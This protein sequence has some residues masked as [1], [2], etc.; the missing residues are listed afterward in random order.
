M[1]SNY[2]TRSSEE[3][4]AEQ[5]S[6]P[7]SVKPTPIYK[8]ISGGMATL[9]RPDTEQRLRS[10]TTNNTRTCVYIGGAGNGGVVSSAATLDRRQPQRMS[11]LNMRRA[12]ADAELPAVTPS[13]QTTR[14]CIS[15]VSSV[16]DSGGGRTTATS[17]RISSSG[18]IT[19]SGSNNTLTDIQGYHEHDLHDG[20]S[21][22]YSSVSATTSAHSAHNITT[23]SNAKLLPAPEDESNQQVRQLAG[24]KGLVWGFTRFSKINNCSWGFYLKRIKSRNHIY[25]FSYHNRKEYVWFVLGFNS[26]IEKMSQKCAFF[27][28][29]IK[30]LLPDIFFALSVFLIWTRKIL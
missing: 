17:G 28:A 22:N 30:R 7:R 29:H 16:V 23:A 18:I 4:L 11:W 20:V 10:D 26:R 3:A 12:K 2:K 27:P 6:L 25:I 15:T 1:S 9:P 21:K 5:L 14:S 19:L 13:P 24:E 8:E